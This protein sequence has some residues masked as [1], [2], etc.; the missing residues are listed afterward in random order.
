MRIDP[1]LI[2]RAK[3]VAAGAAEH[4]SSVDTE[5]RFPQ[6]AMD[7][8]RE[9]RLLGLLIPTELGGE[10]RT[11]REVGAVC[12]V[13]AGGCGSTG[14][15]FAMHHNQI[16]GLVRHGDTD[17]F[18]ERCRR[19]AEGQLLVASATTEIST[20]GDTRSS[21]CA[22]EPAEDGSFT[23]VKNAPVISYG[24][25][26]DLLLLTARANPEAA[27]NDQVLVFAEKDT[28]TLEPTNDWDTM[29][30]RGTCSPGFIATV[31][32]SQDAILPVPFATISAHTMLPASHILW[33][34]VWLGLALTAAEKCRTFVQHAARRTPGV[35]PPSASRLAELNIA[36]DSFAARVHQ[37]A[38]EF[39]SIEPGSDELER[40]GFALAMNGLKIASSTA[41][42]DVVNR[43]MLILGIAGYRNNTPYSMSRL[44]RDAHGAE[45]M[46]NNDRILLNSASMELV[47]RSR[48]P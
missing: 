8:V 17:A 40:M 11:I 22:V 29:G 33:S 48:T 6:E 3:A 16:A 10:G 28:L 1:E 24:D 43:A 15:I 37:A 36:V 13:I 21:T 31:H 20:G 47:R 32:A 7:A 5:G 2:Q 27:A 44:L 39:D 41:V 14:M 25:Y 23:L 42:V 30:F 12:E 46:V 34:S 9:Q 26:A 4:A 45:V 19:I 35:T 38:E 18:R